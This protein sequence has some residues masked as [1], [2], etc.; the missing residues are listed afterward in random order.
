MNKKINKLLIAS[1]ILLIGAGA[2][3]YFLDMPKYVATQKKVSEINNLKN[4]EKLGASHNLEIRTA[5]QSLQEANWAEM[6]KRIDDNFSSDPFYASKMEIFFRDIISRSGMSL[7]SLVFSGS[8]LM[9]GA[10]D[11]GAEKIKSPS[12]SSSSSQQES[13]PSSS[14]GIAGPVKSTKVTISVSGT[15]DQ[16]KGLLNI[17]EKQAYLISVQSINFSGGSI[18]TPYTINVEIYSY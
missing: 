13:R 1:L 11:A 18:I 6:E 9:A 5:E 2:I 17:F 16:L 12:E 14:I 8:S 7:T 10:V 3:V 4:I 15:Y